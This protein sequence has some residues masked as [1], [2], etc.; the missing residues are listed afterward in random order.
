MINRFNLGT[1]IVEN[2]III[3]LVSLTSIGILTTF[4]GTVNQI[5]GNCHYKFK[6]FQPFGKSATAVTNDDLG[7]G[8]VVIVPVDPIDPGVDP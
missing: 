4:G 8:D 1:S 5:L 2:C 6:E 7:G 3:G